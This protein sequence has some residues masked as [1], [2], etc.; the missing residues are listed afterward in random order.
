MQ[1]RDQRHHGV[2]GSNPVR[3]FFRLRAAVE[4]TLETAETVA[5][6]LNSDSLNYQLVPSQTAM[7]AQSFKQKRASFGEKIIDANFKTKDSLDPR[8]HR[9]L[10]KQLMKIINEHHAQKLKEAEPKNPH[11]AAT[12]HTEM[13]QAVKAASHASYNYMLAHDCEAGQCDTAEAE[14][15]EARELVAGLLAEK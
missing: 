12:W 1:T 10:F 6:S 13:C 14:E 9:L 3:R 15:Q 7:S 5:S 2:A 4:Q 8:K 11:L